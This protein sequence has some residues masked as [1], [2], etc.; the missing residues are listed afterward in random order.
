MRD[1]EA[2][3]RGRGAMDAPT[4]SASVRSGTDEDLIRSLRAGDDA[5]FARLVRSWS[6]A[7]LRLARQFVSTSQSAEDAVQD[8]WLGMLKGLDRF[9]GRA[10]LRTWTFSILVN[11]AKSRGVR[12]SKTVVDLGA[13]DAADGRP[14]VDPDRFRGPGDQ[15][16]GGWTPDGVP[17]SWHQ[18]EK[19]AIA[20]ETLGLVEQALDHLPARQ[21]IV[22]TLRDVQG[23]TAD[24]VCDLLD[25]SPGNHRILL[26]RGRGALRGALEEYYRA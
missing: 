13:A 7:M 17:Q 3:A 16:P 10:S 26:H 23:F 14:T 9:E 19:R 5:A 25:I 4:S 2:A 15:Y 22:V 6:P 11:R 24:E 1:P 8:A 12:E 21:R 18:P 20:A